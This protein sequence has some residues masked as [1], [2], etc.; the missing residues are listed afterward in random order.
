MSSE[1]PPTVLFVYSSRL[2]P[3]V[4]GPGELMGML[5]FP[6]YKQER[7][8][9]NR[10]LLGKHGVLEIAMT[11]AR[12]KVKEIKQI[13]PMSACVRSHPRNTWS[14]TGPFRFGFPLM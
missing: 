6:L 2:L 9:N 13:P 4:S 7:Y 5:F 8:K 11:T 1:C 12:S 10:A 14:V 3:D